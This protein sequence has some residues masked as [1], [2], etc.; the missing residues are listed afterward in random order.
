MKKIVIL[1]SGRG[2]NMQAIVQ[3]AQREQW[4]AEIAAVISNKPDAAGLQFAQSQGIPTVVVESKTFASRESFD[5]ALQQEIDKI[6]ADLVVLAGFMRILTPAFVQHYENRII[7]IHPSL[8][9][10]FV[11][12]HTHQQALDAGVKLHGA[13]V[14]FVTAELDHG[15]IIDQACIRVSND[16]TADSLAQRLLEKEHIIYPRAVRLFVEDKLE[17]QGD[18]VLIHTDTSQF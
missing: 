11:G 9:P 18:R 13:T 4:A 14:H 3:A 1:I 5:L 7:N 6:G 16:D 12:L 8:L 2:S 15:P 17:V 10:S